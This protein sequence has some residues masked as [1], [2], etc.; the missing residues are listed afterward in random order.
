MDGNLAIVIIIVSLIAG[1][2][3]KAYVER[4]KPTNSKKPEPFVDPWDAPCE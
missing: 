3:L 2:V 4:N 1:S